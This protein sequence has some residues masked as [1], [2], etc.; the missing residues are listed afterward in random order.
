MS[1]ASSTPTTDSPA[2]DVPH[3]KRWT[4]EEYLRLG[5]LG[6][7]EG[8]KVELIAGEIVQHMS[9][10]GEPHA[11]SIALTA[12][13]LRQ[14]F[15]QG[16]Y[17]RAQFPL[18]LFPGSTPEPDVAV[19]PGSPRD[20]PTAPTT[21]LL[22]VEVSDSTLAFDRR[23][24]A[25]LYAAAGIAEYWIVD[26]RARALEVRRDPIADPAEPHGARYASTFT[27]APGQ[28]LS[29]L[30]APNAVVDPAQLLP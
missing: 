12:D 9:P 16:F 18:A 2:L 15:G 20:Y 25:S 13:A 4:S 11:A 3:V 10:Q 24:K 30:A 23:P 5:E 28:T 8:Q 7:F 29:P 26:L 1:I 22:I 21:A 17:I 19:V 27:V 6:A 14:A